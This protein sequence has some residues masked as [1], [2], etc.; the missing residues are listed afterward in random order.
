MGLCST[1]AEQ[2]PEDEQEAIKRATSQRRRLS[3]KPELVGDISKETAAKEPAVVKGDGKLTE[4]EKKSKGTL[5]T[6]LVSNKGFVPYN[7]NKVNQDRGLIHWALQNNPDLA[8]FGVFDGHGE[9]GHEV[10]QFVID[11]LPKSFELQTDLKDN[12]EAAI[13]AA[14]A[15]THDAL[16]KSEID[17]TYSGTTATFAVKIGNKIYT[18]NAG[19]S[20]TVLARRKAGGGVEGKALS[21]DNKPEQPNEKARIIAAGGRVDP[22]PGDPD[23]DLGPMRVWLKDQDVPGLAM[24]RSIGD[25]VAASV[26]VTSEPVVTEHT[27]G[28]DDLFII[29]ASDGVWEFLSDQEAVELVYK[30]S[31]H[32]DLKKGAE[33]LCKESKLRWQAEED[34][35]D[36]IT[37]VVLEFRAK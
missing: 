11:T 25:E 36:D 22:L 28:D 26:G 35:V 6:C 29:W 32:G 8:L 33:A 7:K 37:A 20:R 10:A 9:F 12:P 3:V 13:K 14:V 23:E 15:H 24:S 19:D 31:S 4:S 1:K 27:M 2:T 34:V 17:F 16:R 30:H 5:N 21:E 18:G